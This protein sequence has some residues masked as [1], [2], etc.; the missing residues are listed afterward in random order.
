MVDHGGIRS[1]QAVRLLALHKYFLNA[2]YLRDAFIRRP[3]RPLPPSEVD[4]VT[5]MDDMIAMSLRYSTTYVVIQGWQK[6]KLSDPELDELLA[7]EE[8]DQLR[9]IRNQMFHYQAEYDN[10]KLLEFLGAGPAEVSSATEWVTGTHR[11]SRQGDRAES[12]EACVTG[13]TTTTSS[14]LPVRQSRRCRP[15]SSRTR[16]STP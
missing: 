5:A 3:K 4:P 11:A 10:P 16:R 7:D 8:L 15:R 9:R 13:Q 14:A 2:D 12:F 6:L 1:V